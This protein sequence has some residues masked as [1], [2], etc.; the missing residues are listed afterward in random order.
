MDPLPPQGECALKLLDGRSLCFSPAWDDGHGSVVFDRN[1]GDFW[2]VTKQARALLQ[3]VADNP[4]GV[5]M[6]AAESDD[7]DSSALIRSLEQAGLLEGRGD[8]EATPTRLTT[9]QAD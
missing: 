4:N 2:I 8:A 5:P 7:D 6:R 1:S 9:T 3:A